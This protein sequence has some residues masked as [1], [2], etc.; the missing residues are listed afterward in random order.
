MSFENEM[1]AQGDYRTLEKNTTV[2]YLLWI[3]LGMF[4]A[5]RFYVRHTGVAVAQLL[6]TLTVFGAAVTFVWVIVDA[7]LLPDILRRI[8]W[9]QLEERRSFYETVS[10]NQLHRPR[11]ELTD[12]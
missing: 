10:Y 2:A 8:N 7:F 12:E 6:L 11:H 1:R 9:A 5:H 3:F 4:G